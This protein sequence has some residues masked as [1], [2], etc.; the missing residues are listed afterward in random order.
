MK[1]I[2]DMLVIRYLTMPNGRF[3]FFSPAIEQLIGVPAETLTGDS[4]W[5]RLPSGYDESQSTSFQKLI[6][7]DER[8]RVGEI[9]MKARQ[10]VSFFGFEYRLINSEQREIW[11]F[12]EGCFHEDAEGHIRLEGS[13]LNI[14]NW[15]QTEIV[16]RVLYQISNAVN[17]TQDL[18]A[19][20]ASIHSALGEI[21]NVDS[22]YIAIYNELKDRICFPFN[23]DSKGEYKSNV[24]ENASKSSSLTWEII[25][26]KQPKLLN[27]QEQKQQAKKMGGPLLGNASRQWLGVPLLVRERVIGAMVTQSYKDPHLYTS[28]EIDIMTS[29]S[30]QIAMAIDR[31]KAL[32]D[33]KKRELQLKALYSISNATLVS[34]A[35]DDLFQKVLDSLWPVIDIMDFT[36]ALYD[37]ERD[38]L[39]FPYSTDPEAKSLR[40][41]A[42]SRSSSITYQVIKEGRTLILDKTEQTELITSLGGKIYGRSSESWVGVPLVAKDGIIGVIISQNYAEPNKYDDAYVEML[43]LVSE[44]IVLSLE[45]R[46]TDMDLRLAR[47]ELEQRVRERTLEL[48]KIN[49]ELKAEISF[50]KITEE[51]LIVAKQQA[52]EANQAK[53]EFL[54]NIS[55]ELRTPM[56]HILNY[57]RMGQQKIGSIGDD[58]LKHYFTQSNTSGKRLMRLLDDLLDIS[59]LEAGKM[60]YEMQLNDV[61][62]IAEHTIA[63]LSY[64]FIEKSIEVKIIESDA[65]TKA[66]CDAFRIGQVLQNLLDNAIK[67]T[68][69][70]K[71]VTLEFLEEKNAL[72]GN[73]YLKTIITDQGIGI[74]EDELDSVFDKFTQSS[75]TK[76]GAGGTGLGLPICQE[77]IRGHHGFIR[78]KNHE[79]EGTISIFSIPHASVD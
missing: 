77:I 20:Y 13:I 19:L 1:L 71:K 12:E 39:T 48:A 67:Y 29:V 32:E 33:L 56:H 6:H 54:A 21:L 72:T 42:A 62:E 24:I 68:P 66:V 46:K 52:E 47:D 23:T 4:G 14:Q 11:I 44:Q 16:N 26:T 8:D 59:R 75:R 34:P 57:T 79:K 65:D 63:E 73:R 76:T 40:I 51:K 15:K 64:V 36:I 55:H 27:E 78:I 3:E 31:R 22:F 74:P 41:E 43:Q 7:P 28:K 38:E 30:D 45:R 17:T 70:G 37:K 9:L 50:R 25:H 2:E 10:E 49:R 18:E 60:H 5:Q 69:N 53:S 35:L 58:K 61:R